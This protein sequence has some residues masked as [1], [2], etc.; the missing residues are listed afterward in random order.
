MTK[1]TIERKEIT[2]DKRPSPKRGSVLTLRSYDEVN[3]S[4]EK[5]SDEKRLLSHPFFRS[6]SKLFK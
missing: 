6:L 3:L 1:K 5:E 4:S 2:W